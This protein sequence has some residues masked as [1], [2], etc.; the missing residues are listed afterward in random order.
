[1]LFRERRAART[2]YR[3]AWGAPDVCERER[4]ERESERERERERERTQHISEPGCSP[5]GFVAAATRSDPLKLPT[6]SSEVTHLVGHFGRARPDARQRNSCISSLVYCS[7]IMLTSKPT[8]IMQSPRGRKQTTWNSR[9]TTQGRRRHPRLLNPLKYDKAHV[10]HI[11][12]KR[13]VLQAQGFCKARVTQ[14]NVC[15][16]LGFSKRLH[17]QS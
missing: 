6:P 2:R 12:F 16:R 11:Y 10:G 5:N 15:V 4:R 14:S 7:P 9:R 13:C 1:M 3:S 17:Q 8:R